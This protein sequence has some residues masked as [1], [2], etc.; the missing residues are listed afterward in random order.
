MYRHGPLGFWKELRDHLTVKTRVETDKS[1]GS[2]PPV[3]IHF[4]IGNIIPH[5]SEP[6]YHLLL[7]WIPASP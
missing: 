3:I 7:Q 6:E 2:D 4:D 1:V 5:D